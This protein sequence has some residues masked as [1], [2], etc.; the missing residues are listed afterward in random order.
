MCGR[1]GIFNELGTLAEAFDFEMPNLDDL[2]SP[3]FNIAP[4]M[5]V[6]VVRPSRSSPGQR[7]VVSMR[8][9]LIPPWAKRDAIRQRPL[10][11]AR[12]ETISEHPTFRTPFARQRCLIPASGFYEW[13]Q[14]DAGKKVPMWVSPMDREVPVGFAGIWSYWRNGDQ[15][16]L[17]C[18][19][20]TTVANDLMSQIHPRMPVIIEPEHHA[21]WL[22]AD[23]DASDLLLM[24]QPR[25]WPGM[26]IEP[27][28]PELL[29]Q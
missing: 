28:D 11:N 16:V 24:L 19:I 4:T 10:F 25:D 2:Y 1:F 21:T 14:V 13:T 26:V 5:S 22:T 27:A 15:P 17:S 3:S 23:T 8:W 20:I 12:A 7:E 29:K 9:G 6:L 18:S